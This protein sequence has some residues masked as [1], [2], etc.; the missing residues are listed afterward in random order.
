MS[1]KWREGAGVLVEGARRD[2]AQ[3]SASARG[4]PP[5]HQP[6]AANSPVS[7]ST[8]S[9]AHLHS[10]PD[11]LHHFRPQAAPY[12]PCQRLPVHLPCPTPPISCPY[13]PCPLHSPAHLQSKADHLHHPQPTAAAYCQSQCLPTPQRTCRARLTTRTIFIGSYTSGHVSAAM[14]LARDAVAMRRR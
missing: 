1:Q 12:Y 8:C 5:K 13:A 2:K 10:A 4:R 3:L 6:A 9:P 7:N 14:T 11:Y